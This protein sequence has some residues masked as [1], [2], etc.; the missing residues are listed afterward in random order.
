MALAGC[1]FWYLCGAAMTGETP[2][3]SLRARRCLPRSLLGR[4]LGI[5]YTPGPATGYTLAVA[6]AVSSAVVVGF[7]EAARRALRIMPA[8]TPPFLQG[9]IPLLA[10]TLAAY[11]T[12][13]LGL[14]WLLIRLLR[15]ISPFGP[16]L[17]TI[18][19]GL[20]VVAGALIPLGI[21]SAMFRYN[22]GDNYSLLQ[23]TNVFW[24]SHY[25]VTSVY[26]QYHYMV[27]LVAAPALLVFALNLPAILPRAREMPI[28]LPRRVAEEDAELARQTR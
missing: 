25:I 24:T 3:L 22:A 19:Q 28:A 23:L 11:V 20:L 17:A 15:R 12:F 13:Y 8:G 14:G 4:A 5:W 10:A 21:A 9:R 18:I 6:G 2:E 16:L 26:F 1:L 27:W 7:F